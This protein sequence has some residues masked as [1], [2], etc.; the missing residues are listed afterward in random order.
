MAA[1]PK[2]FV[3]DGVAVCN[4]EVGHQIGQVVRCGD[5]GRGAGGQPDTIG[6]H[7]CGIRQGEL[8]LS[9][10]LEVDG[11]DSRAG[12]E[13]LANFLLRIDAGKAVDKRECHC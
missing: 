3:D 1:E 10:G 6:G 4:G 5:V 12:T 7:T 2:R 9:A 11:L 8:Q 13:R